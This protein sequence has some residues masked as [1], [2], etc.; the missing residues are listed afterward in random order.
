MGLFD[1]GSDF[2]KALEGIFGC[3]D[4]FVKHFDEVV[5]AESITKQPEHMFIEAEI[6]GL[7]RQ[8]H[9]EV[10]YLQNVVRTLF[11]QNETQTKKLEEFQEKKE[12]MSNELQI[13]YDKIAT[14]NE[15]II[16]LRRIIHTLEQTERIQ[17]ENLN[18]LV[19]NVKKASIFQEEKVQAL[20]HI[21]EVIAGLSGSAKKA[22]YE[23][24]IKSIKSVLPD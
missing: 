8:H 18:L 22:D 12:D 7:K 13:R 14:L 9:A 19:K 21:T 15:T 4:D 20:Q 5:G 16:N 2:V 17:E 6:E 23:K 11:L 3:D 24:V 10:K 1:E